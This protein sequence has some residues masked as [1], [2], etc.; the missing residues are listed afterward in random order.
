MIYKR[1]SVLVNIYSYIIV[2]IFTASFKPREYRRPAILPW[3]LSN[4]H[5]TDILMSLTSHDG[6]ITPLESKI[7]FDR[8][9]IL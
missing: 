6:C 8:R 9:Y 5:Q 7:F 4:R 1:N 3:S 2:F